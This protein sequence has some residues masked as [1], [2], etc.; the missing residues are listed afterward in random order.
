MQNR[1]LLIH[2]VG[3]S[4]SQGVETNDGEDC[5][6]GVSYGVEPW[7]GGGSRVVLATV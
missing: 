5:V 3:Y 1:M 7:E 4:S 6:V 2:F